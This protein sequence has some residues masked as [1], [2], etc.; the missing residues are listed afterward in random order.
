MAY[1]YSLVGSSW[2][3]GISSLLSV[4]VRQNN[5]IWCL[6]LL[7][8]RIVTVYEVGIG[9]IRGNVIRSVVSFGRL[10]LVNFKDIVKANYVQMLVFPIFGWYLYKYNNSKLVFG[11][12]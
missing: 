9:G 7:V 10:M 2:R 8:Y 1:Y 6:F 11:D 4:Y 12:H 5:I 3:M